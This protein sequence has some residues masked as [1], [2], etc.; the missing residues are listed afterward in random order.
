MEQAAEVCVTTHMQSISDILLS[1]VFGGN[2][3]IGESNETFGCT[4]DGTDHAGRLWHIR[5]RDAV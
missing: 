1:R 3:S 2:A 4:F 5:S